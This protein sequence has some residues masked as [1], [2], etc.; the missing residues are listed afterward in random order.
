MKRAADVGPDHHLVIGRVKLKLRRFY[1]ATTKPG[2]RYNTSL[3]RDPETKT[4]FYVEI[5]N[6]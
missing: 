1:T 5:F 4:K 2:H 3:L 6:R